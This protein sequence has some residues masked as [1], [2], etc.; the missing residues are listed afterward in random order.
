[1][2]VDFY[3]NLIGRFLADEITAQ[4]FRL[5][6]LTAFK[7]EPAGMDDALFEILQDLFEDVDAYS[8]LW[9][10][11]DESATRLTEQTLRTE[12]MEALEQLARLEGG[13][14]SSA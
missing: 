12:T 10:E 13:E 5:K 4:Q 14:G 2:R 8:P 6:Y 11:K 9:T 7:R 3:R 1:M